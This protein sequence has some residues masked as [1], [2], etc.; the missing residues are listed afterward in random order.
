MRA[1]SSRHA[2]EASRTPTEPIAN[3]EWRMQPRAN[4]DRLQGSIAV[5]HCAQRIDED[6]GLERLGD[7]HVCADIETLLVGLGVA[8]SGHEDDRQLA[9]RCAPLTCADSTR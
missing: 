2:T 1:G 5:E 8:L 3:R 6:V 9:V 7:V 4:L